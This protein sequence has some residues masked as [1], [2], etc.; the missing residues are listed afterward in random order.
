MTQLTEKECEIC[1]IAIAKC[2][3]I[4]LM[5]T[6]GYWVKATKEEMEELL[7]KLEQIQKEAIAEK[8]RV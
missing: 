6:D 2:N 4:S 3:I 7:R 8:K 5:V 1:G